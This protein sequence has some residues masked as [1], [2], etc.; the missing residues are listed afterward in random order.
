MPFVIRPYRRLPTD[1]PVTY[2]RLYDTGHGTVWNV[3]STGFRVSGTLPLQ[4]DDVCSL[5]LKLPKQVAVLAGVVRWVHGDEF[6]IETLLMDRRDEARLA[7]FIR[8]RMQE[9]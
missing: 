4:L 7:A 2:E 8:G 5:T 3:S 1:C 6:G 9:L